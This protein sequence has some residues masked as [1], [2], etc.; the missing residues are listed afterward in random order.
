[1]NNLTALGELIGAQ[2]QR[3]RKAGA[4]TVLELGTVN[5]DLSLSVD[6]L[7]DTVPKGEYLLSLHLTALSGDE[8][9]SIDT[10]HTHSGG[11]H[12][13]YAGDGAHSHYDGTHHHVLPEAFRGI[14]PNDRVLVAWA[15]GQPVVLEIISS[16]RELTLSGR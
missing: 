11:G 12:Y 5:G 6:S 16:G 1:M 13:Q 9:H 8:L 7:R 3:V 4:E 10:A 15:G 2:M 14:R